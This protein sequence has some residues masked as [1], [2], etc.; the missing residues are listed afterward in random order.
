MAT[1]ADKI[2][3]EALSLP[4]DM[5]AAVVDRL[6]ESLNIP[7]QRDVDAVWAG[8]AEKRFKE[9]SEG[10]VETVEGEVVFREIRKKLKK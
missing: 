10:T 7:S 1:L 9:I 3:K 5:R 4:N 6:L 2:V 8:E